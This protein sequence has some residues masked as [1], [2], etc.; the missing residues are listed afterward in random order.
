MVYQRPHFQVSQEG[1]ILTVTWAP[2]FEGTLICSPQDV[3]P[4]Y[5]AYTAFQAL[6]EEGT[7]AR[8]HTL[9]MRLKPGQCL[10]FNNRR[11]L[12][13]RE[14]FSGEGSRL[15]QGCYINIDDAMSRL[16]A[17]HMMRP[18]SSASDPLEDQL[19]IPGNGSRLVLTDH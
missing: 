1:D 12:H 14:A 5:E 9:R 13:G 11:L 10:V 8:E 15:L 16:R 4:Y 17:M 19:I 6:L 2:Q 18:F 3:G 7:F